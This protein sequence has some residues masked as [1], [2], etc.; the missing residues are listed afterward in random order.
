M[1][2]RVD[3]AVDARL[4]GVRA[5]ATEADRRPGQGDRLRGTDLTTQCDELGRAELEG[6][7]IGRLDHKIEKLQIIKLVPGTE[8]LRSDAFRVTGA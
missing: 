1:F 7:P 3:D 2:S 5:V 6:T 4:K 8:F